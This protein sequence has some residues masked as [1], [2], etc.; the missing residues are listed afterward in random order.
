M[1][2]SNYLDLV[3]DLNVVLDSVQVTKDQ[4]GN[5]TM[6]AAAGWATH[7]IDYGSGA[8][9]TT[10]GDGVIHAVEWSTT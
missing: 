2:K 10:N 8:G 3:Y 7:S 4:Y 5:E 6:D 9:V 1:D